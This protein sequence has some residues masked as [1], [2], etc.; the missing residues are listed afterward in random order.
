M[1]IFAISDLHLSEAVHKPMDIFGSVW[2]AHKEKIE[3]NWRKTVSDGD[4]VLV[5]GDISWGMSFEEAVPDLRFIESLPGRKILMSG[6]HDYWWT[7]VSK[8]N[9]LF[10]NMVFI[11]NTFY[12]LGGTAICGSRGWILPSDDSFT[13]QDDKIYKR[14][15]IRLKLS[16]DGAKRAGIDDI[17]CMMHYPPTNAAGDETGFTEVFEQYGIKTVIYGHLHGTKAF[18]TGVKGEVRGVNYALV[19]ADYLEFMPVRVR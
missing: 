4:T 3:E 9:G 2:T 11:K 5:P 18:E 19:S 7:S 6:N 14:E 1:G 16:L 10:S 8:M 17:I 15:I 12:D 13:A